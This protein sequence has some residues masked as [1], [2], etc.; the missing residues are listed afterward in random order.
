MDELHISVDVMRRIV[1][2]IIVVINRF[3]EWI[4]YFFMYSFLLS[5]ISYKNIYIKYGL[6]LIIISYISE[7]SEYEQ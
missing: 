5:I 4:K 6:I 7:E 3:M 2:L 1:M